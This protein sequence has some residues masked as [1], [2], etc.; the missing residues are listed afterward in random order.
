MLGISP[1][2]LAG[3]GSERNINQIGPQQSPAGE[4]FAKD[5]SD[6]GVTYKLLSHG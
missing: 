5:S 4:L 2:I 3:Q 1:T 6:E